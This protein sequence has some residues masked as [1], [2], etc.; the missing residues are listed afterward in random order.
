VPPSCKEADKRPGRGPVRPFVSWAR[1]AGDRLAGNADKTAKNLSRRTEVRVAKPKKVAKTPKRAGGTPTTGALHPVRG[2]A[3][4]VVSGLAKIG[5]LDNRLT[6]QLL[7][8]PVYGNYCGRGHGDPTGNKPPVDAVDAACREHDLCYARLGDFDGRCDRDLVE[9]M[10]SAIASTPSPIG[11]KAGIL[12]MLYFS[13]VER[14]TAL[15]E[16]LSRRPNAGRRE[17][18]PNGVR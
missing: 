12:T 6:S 4:P 5:P 17:G 16:S 1:E 15:G 11:K 13:L 9:S 18:F 2:I 14:N 7:R 10:P 3:V 8:L